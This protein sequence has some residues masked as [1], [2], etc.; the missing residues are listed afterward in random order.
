[1]NQK[2]TEPLFFSVQSQNIDEVNGIIKSVVI[3]HE[4]ETKNGPVMD[5]ISLSQIVALGNS[6]TQGVKSRFG[7]PNMCNSA[8]GT[9]IGRFKNFSTTENASGKKIVIADLHLDDTA[10]DLPKIGNAFDYII[11]MAKSN[12]DMFGNSMV[13]SPDKRFKKTESDKYGN[14]I[15]KEFERLKSFI[16]SDL[17]DSPAATDSLFN[18]TEDFAFLATDF[19]DSNPKVFEVLEKNPEVIEEFLNKYTEYKKNKMEKLTIEDRI[20]AIT[21]HVDDI[22][23][24]DISAVTKDGGNIV[25]IDDDNSG[26]PSV[27]DAVV[28]DTGAPVVSQK[29]VLEDDTT[30]E[31]DDKGMITAITGPAPVVSNSTEIAELKN[32]LSEL[33]K[34]YE[35]DTENLLSSVTKLTNQLSLMQGKLTLKTSTTLFPVSHE[36]REK[37]SEEIKAEILE[38]RKKTNQIEIN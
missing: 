6:Q 30:I 24:M 9:Y 20:K 27:G 32:Q 28:D 19:M 7:H 15:T 11:K 36:V 23:K 37:T 26:T 21:K 34:K 1:M 38:R 8:L 2:K 14:Q 3:I 25:I 10:K 29:I 13:Y 22:V 35:S 4:G 31:T 16:A 12:N 33:T 18:D 17:V 5:E